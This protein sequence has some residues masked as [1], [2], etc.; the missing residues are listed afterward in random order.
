MYSSSVSSSGSSSA[1]WASIYSVA[2]TDAA[3]TN[4]ETRC[5]TPSSITRPSVNRWLLFTTT[6]G[7]SRISRSTTCSLDTSP[8]YR[9]YVSQCYFTIDKYSIIIIIRIRIIRIIICIYYHITVTFTGINFS[10][11]FVSVL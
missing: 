6:P 8:F 9:S 4:G 1:S 11:S 2:S 7:S 3:L 10:F 5:L